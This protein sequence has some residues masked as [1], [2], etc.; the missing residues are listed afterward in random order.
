MHDASASATDDEVLAVAECVVRVGAARWPF[1]EMH[2]AEIDSH[3][4]EATRRN[5]HFFDGVVLMTS[6]FAVREGHLSVEL[7]RTRFRNYLYWRHRGFAG[8]GVVDGFG[9]G[10]IR[11][12]DGAIV[13][14]RQNAGNV[15]EGLY[16]TPSGFIDTAD[17][18]AQG[19]VD[20]AASVTREIVEETGLNPATLRRR[21]GFIVAR[22]GAQL[23]I[24]VLFDSA[25]AA[26]ALG[27]SIRDAIARQ[28]RP[29][30]AEVR[31]VR[32]LDD[33]LGLDV[34]P[35]SRLHL[36]ALLG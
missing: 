12:A 32:R 31:L 33:T 11:S 13:L 18:N 1:A 5:R 29:E 7:F 34:A 16:Y 3:W 35:H 9:S 17:I 15:N 24:G 23:A 27:Q 20:I 25:L 10:L 4:Q 19:Y 8:E 2:A 28:E 26:D 14:V 21:P 22:T 36:R 30:L 6:R